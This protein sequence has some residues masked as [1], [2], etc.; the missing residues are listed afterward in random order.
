MKNFIK[1]E[2]VGSWLDRENDTVYP[3]FK[4]GLP[5][6]DSPMPLLY[7]ILEQKDQGQD[8]WWNSLSK[9]DNELIF[10]GKINSKFN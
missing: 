1:L 9:R 5:D 8:E 2:S 10:H 6:L 3:T 7:C 4:N